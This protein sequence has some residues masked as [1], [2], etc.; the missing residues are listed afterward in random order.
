ME[1][2]PS[3]ET[4]ST[5]LSVILEKNLRL[6]KNQKEKSK[7]CYPST[8]MLGHSPPFDPLSF[9]KYLQN[10]KLQSFALDIDYC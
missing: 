4:D 9:N 1:S 3:G 7:H 10:S 2:H 5:S 8:P 6:K